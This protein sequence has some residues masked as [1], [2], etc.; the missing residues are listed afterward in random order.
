MTTLVLIGLLVAATTSI[1]A[2]AQ[3]SPE[4]EQAATAIRMRQYQQASE[5]LQPLAAEGNAEAQYQLASLYRSGRGVKQDLQEF[6]R[7]LNASA[8]GGFGRAQYQLGLAY[9]TGSMVEAD[10][11]QARYWYT[12]AAQQGVVEAAAR[13]GQ[14]DL[15]E[16][17]NSAAADVGPGVLLSAVL[18]GN[19][20]LV[21]QL[22]DSGAPVDGVDAHGRT[23]LLDVASSGDLVILHL[24]LDHGAN[25]D[26]QDSY[27][28]APLLAAV[29][30]GQTEVLGVPC[31]RIMPTRISGTLPATPP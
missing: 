3:E 14:L 8:T 12:A 27:G 4:L 2:Q 26:A 6:L 15:N 23:A 1:P 30:A 25:P 16:P 10:P 31:W 17:A 5:L 21:Q 19:S 22:L 20:T 9:E 29:R 11:A 24:L 13:L 28:D 18:Q 7:L